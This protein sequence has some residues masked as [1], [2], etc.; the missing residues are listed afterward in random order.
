MSQTRVIR[1]VT[2]TP[3]ELTG[4]GCSNRNL[5]ARMRNSVVNH[6]T[7][8]LSPLCNATT[9]EPIDGFPRKLSDLGSYNSASFSCPSV[10]D[11]QADAAWYVVRQVDRL[12]CELGEPVQGSAD[13]RRR[14]L[15]YA[16]GVTTQVV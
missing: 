15:K 16:I 12:L 14:W 13:D 11:L 2:R 8:E 10:L 9:G 1:L 5:T 7:V 6:S 3:R 4:S